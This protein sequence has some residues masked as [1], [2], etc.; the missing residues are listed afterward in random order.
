MAAFLGALA[1]PE[2]IKLGGGGGRRAAHVEA[3]IRIL[4]R[5][6]RV[7]D[8]FVISFHLFQIKS[9]MHGLQQLHVDIR[10][11]ATKCCS[12]PDEPPGRKSSRFVSR[13]YQQR[14]RCSK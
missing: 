10:Q 8:A 14:N 12:E 3:S 1:I 9:F 2:N 13:D 6:R 5:W 7:A 4:M 11:Y